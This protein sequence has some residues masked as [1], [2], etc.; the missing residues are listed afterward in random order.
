ML[1]I[2]AET[3]TKNFT[4]NTIDLN[5]S[6]PPQ[7]KVLHLDV[8]QAQAGYVSAEGKWIPDGFMDKANIAFTCVRA[9]LPQLS[10]SIIGYC[11]MASATLFSDI[12]SVATAYFDVTSS[13]TPI[14][15]AQPRVVFHVPCGFRSE[16]GR[17]LSWEQSR[18]PTARPV[19]AFS[20][21]R[22]AAPY[23]AGPTGAY[24]L[25]FGTA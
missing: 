2:H 22:C 16:T 1:P 14:P 12:A 3:Q 10:D 20:V 6:N 18:V 15:T 7:C 5:N 25:G 9:R 23:V 13:T 11:L 17:A 8:S 21:L 19:A 24:V 4:C